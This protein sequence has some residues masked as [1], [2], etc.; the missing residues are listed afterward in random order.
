[1]FGQ[2]KGVFQAEDVKKAWSLACSYCYKN[3]L[4]PVNLEIEEVRPKTENNH[5]TR[6]DH[7]NRR[8]DYAKY[9]D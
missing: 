5:K 2:V 3:N 9:R 6:N 7:M 8:N 4:N 1:M